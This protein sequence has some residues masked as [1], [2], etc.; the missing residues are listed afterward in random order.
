MIRTRNFQ[1]TAWLVSIFFIFFIF[2][3]TVIVDQASAKRVFIRFGGSNPGGSWFTI[4][5]GITALFNKEIEGFNASPVA[6]GGSTDVNRQARKHH[7]D[8]WLTQSIT[9]YDNWT[10]TGIFEGQGKFQDFRMLSGVY[11]SWHHFVAL[12][13]SGIK[14]MSD[15]KGKTVAVGAAGSGAAENS[16]FV[17]NALGLTGQLKPL[18]LT[19]DASGR[20]VS[21]GQADAIGMSSAPMP[22]VVTLEAMHKIHMIALNDQELDMVIKKYPAFHKTVMPAGVYKSWNKPYPCIAF[23][24][25]WSAHKDLDP[26]VVYDM[27]KVAFDP[28]NKDFLSKVH[29]QLTTLSPSL[30]G[31]A[32]MGI[33]LHKG[34]VKYWKEKGLTIPAALIKD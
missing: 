16:I 14:T 20:A 26:D 33:P 1:K 10:G 15:L 32:Q 8:T 5:G 2:I 29:V 7:L 24:V 22:A 13:K 4:A 21:D 23:H 27:L 6:T 31:M 28:K 30:E 34:A 18:F 17:F 19:F 9:A 11:E 25:Y 12:E 3:S